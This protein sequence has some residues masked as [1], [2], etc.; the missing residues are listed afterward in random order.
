MSLLKN[1]NFPPVPSPVRPV[2]PDTRR[3]RK[4]DGG[5]GDGRERCRGDI[6]GAKDKVS[7][8]GNP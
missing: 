7:A 1:Y 2:R 6:V 8:R 3:E 4:T 5:G